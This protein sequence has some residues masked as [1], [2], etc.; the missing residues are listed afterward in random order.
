MCNKEDCRQCKDV[1]ILCFCFK[2]SALFECTFAQVTCALHKSEFDDQII[3][4]FIGTF[5][6]FFFYWLTITFIISLL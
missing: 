6:F 4:L 5:F 2:C 3:A 1:Y